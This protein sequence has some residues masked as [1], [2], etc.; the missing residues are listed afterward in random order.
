MNQ[1]KEEKIPN[2]I[3]C[4]LLP[5]QT[6]F[7]LLPNVSIAEVLS[8]EIKT[9]TK[10]PPWHL[11][12]VDWRT[13]WVP[14]IAFEGLNNHPVAMPDGTVRIAILNSYGKHSMLPFYGLR[15]TGIPRLVRIFQQDLIVEN[16]KVLPAEI[17]HVSYQGDRLVIPDLSYIEGELLTRR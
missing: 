2:E 16:E 15:I 14:V 8:G 7:L 5:T 1:V 11:G 17:M 13:L 4:L 10:T 9:N 12:S 6:G 3:P